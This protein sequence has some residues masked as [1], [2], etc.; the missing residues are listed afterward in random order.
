MP[1]L[2]HFHPP[3]STA[4]PWEGIHSN[5]ATKIADQLNLGLLPADYVA[6]PQVTVGGQ[7]EV[8]VATFQ[9]GKADLSGNDGVT[10]M[11]WAPAKPAL[12][13][14]I[15]FPVQDVYEVQIRQEMGGPKLRAAIEL[16]S[17]G[18]KDRPANRHAFA[19]KCAAYLHKGISV[20]VI[21][22]VTDR[23]FNLPANLVEVLHLPADFGWRSATGLYTI[24]YRLCR[25][26]NQT[27]VQAWPET[28]KIGEPL[29]TM[30]LWL[31]DDLCLP[32]P[33][34]DSYR[35]T[36]RSLRIAV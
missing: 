18:N 31:D 29:P 2:D 32:L 11:V 19:L 35:A 17:P 23:V 4:R 6:I 20:M 30:P 27:Q 3:L 21:D 7:V 8:D 13:T 34:E 25:A 16:V 14:A 26:G 9:E 12:S 36:C 1:L 15:E 24:A 28:L 5:W 33:L 22:I 10:T